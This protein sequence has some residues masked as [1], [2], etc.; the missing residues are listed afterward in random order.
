MF[1]NVSDIV[2]ID[3][4]GRHQHFRDGHQ[5]VPEVCDKQ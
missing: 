4:K 5:C 2:I 1:E 3:T